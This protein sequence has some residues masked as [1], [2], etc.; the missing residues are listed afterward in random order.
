VAPPSRHATD[1][2]GVVRIVRLGDDLTGPLLDG[3]TEE[4]QNRYGSIDE[5]LSVDPREFEPP[6]GLFVVVVVAGSPVSGGGFRR[7]TPDTCE[8]KRMWTHARHRRQGWATVVLGSLEAAARERGYSRLR[9]E[10]GPRQP[11]AQEMYARRG[12]RSI[13]PYGSYSQASAFEL[14]LDPARHND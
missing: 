2:D 10:T 12:Y 13:A 7:L 14:L 6:D 3:L 1:A 9:L 4:Y 11:E 5:M 8:V